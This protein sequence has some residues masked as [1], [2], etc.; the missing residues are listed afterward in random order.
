MATRAGV[1]YSSFTTLFRHSFGLPTGFS[2]NVVESAERELM[3]L[4]LTVNIGGLIPESSREAEQYKRCSDG[5]T[6]GGV[7]GASVRGWLPPFDMSLVQRG[8]LLG[9]GC[10]VRRVCFPKDYTAAMR[11]STMCTSRSSR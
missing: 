4:D 7:G 5:L 9:K 6:I 8:P 2:W 11:Q 3:V 1:Q 10:A